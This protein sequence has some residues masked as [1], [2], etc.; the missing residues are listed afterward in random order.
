M[1]LLSLNLPH[2]NSWPHQ[3]LPPNMLLFSFHKGRVTSHCVS[4]AQSSAYQT[5]A[6]MLVK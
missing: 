6:L 1:G 3:H 2:L 5:P 4:R